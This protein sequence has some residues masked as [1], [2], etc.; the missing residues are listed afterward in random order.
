MMNFILELKS[1]S[2][3]VVVSCFNNLADLELHGFMKNLTN[4]RPQR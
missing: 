2:T 1:A 3:F 4:S